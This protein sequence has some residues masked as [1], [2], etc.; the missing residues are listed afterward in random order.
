MRDIGSP[1]DGL[2]GSGWGIAKGEE[3]KNKN[4]YTGKDIDNRTEENGYG[5]K[6]EEKD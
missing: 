1:G 2:K 5:E 6:A 4:G 3:G